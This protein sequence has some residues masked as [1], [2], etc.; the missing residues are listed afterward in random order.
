VNNYLGKRI[1]SLMTV[2]VV[3]AA[4]LLPGAPAQTPGKV[5]PNAGL[6]HVLDLEKRFGPH[7][8]T[9][10]SSGG[11]NVFQS[12]KMLSKMQARG[13]SLRARASSDTMM[14]SA[15]GKLLAQGAKTGSNFP[16][17]V[18]NPSFDFDTTRFTGFTQNETSSAWCGNNIVVGFNDSAAFAH[19]ALQ[20]QAPAISLS[21][22]AVSHNDG[23]SFVGLPFLNPGPAINPGS[24][25]FDSELE[26]DPVLVCSDPQH[27]AYA[28]IQIQVPVDAQG[29]VIAAFTNMAVS[30]SSDGGVTWD[31]PIITVSKDLNSHFL[32]KEWLAVDPRNSNNLYL[33]YTDFQAHGTEPDCVGGT[34]G[35][36]SGPD[37]ALEMVSSK[38]GGLTWSAPVRFAR[39]CSLNIGENLSG[40]Q[41]VVGRNG[42]VYVAYAE[43][44]DFG[45]DGQIVFRRSDDGGATFDPEIV[46]GTTVP[47]ANPVIPQLQAFFRTNVFPTLA[48][49]NS[50][51]PRGGSL[52]LAWTDASQNAIEDLL[53][54]F[55]NNDFTCIP[56]GCG[57]YAFGD[58]VFSR[59]LDG[60]NT[61]SPQTLVSPT[62]A[63]FQGA[64]RD[65]FMSGVAA[66]PRGD[67]AV[68]YSDRRNDP[69]NFLVDHYCSISHDQGASFADVRE[70]PASW[71]PNA[72][73][74]VLLNPV[75]LGDYD[76]V[77]TDAT[78]ANPGFFN[79]FQMLTKGNPD[80]F[81][82]KVP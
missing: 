13:T 39:R 57:G 27:F 45:L 18:N 42:T 54:Q 2:C 31:D 69:N 64:G 11:A 50:S 38:D 14:S 73:I 77:S 32:D 6:A 5:K 67:V 70:T 47:P 71:E 43:V 81:G 51:G 59:S 40:T 61:W 41:V 60:G 26:G 17:I 7:F 66:D 1:F 49:D 28:N 15:R 82:F 29:N 35:I 78:R 62:P 52:Y 16:V 75:Y 33:T 30:R 37:A 56:D 4:L 22:V 10:L 53:I 55:F 72:F 74:D 48:V 25:F 68:C 23:S 12:A 63:N 36:Q 80:V 3:H 79:T 46:A 58:I 44:N 76:T 34:I 20:G 9:R 21:G 8:A 19:T 65:Q 24:P